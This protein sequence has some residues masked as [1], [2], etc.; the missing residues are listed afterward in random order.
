MVDWFAEDFGTHVHVDPHGS[1]V[2]DAHT[3]HGE[4]Y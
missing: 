1:F 4:D 3:E 2:P